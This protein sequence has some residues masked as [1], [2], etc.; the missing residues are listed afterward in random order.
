MN[1][2]RK[3]DEYICHVPDLEWGGCE[4]KSKNTIEKTDN[5]IFVIGNEIHFSCGINKDTIQEI[6]K[7][8]SVLIHDHKEQSGGTPEKLTITY[9]VDSPGGSV[10]S[11]L[12]FVDYLNIVRSK[13]K[14]VKFVSIISGMSASAGTI[15]A[16]VA[17]KKY[18]TEN[19]HAMIHELS[20][21]NSS[22]YTELMSYMDYLSKLHV[23]LV[24][25]YCKN[26]NKS[27]KEIEELLRKETWFSA[28]EYHENGFVDGIKTSK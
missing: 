19:A 8:M 23:T 22:K 10:T 14:W 17:D 7:M 27:V 6:I 24:N 26:T 12:K 2:K 3:F 28:Q 13:Y 18:I 16:I 15:M 11:V 25:I 5:G 9:I 4:K 21:G 20:A 1:K